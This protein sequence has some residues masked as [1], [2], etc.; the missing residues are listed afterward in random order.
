VTEIPYYHR[1]K[2]TTQTDKVADMQEESQEMWGGPKG[3]HLSNDDPIVKAYVGK[4]SRHR[5]KGVEFTTI[6]KPDGYHPSSVEWSVREGPREGVWVEGGY[7]KI[8]ISTTY[9]NQGKYATNSLDD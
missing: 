9:C 6:V 4:L 1:K 2:S 3:N 8:K 5:D 7:A